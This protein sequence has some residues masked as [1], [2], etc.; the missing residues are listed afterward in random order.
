[1]NRQ[2][3]RQAARGARK[4]GSAASILAAPLELQSRFQNAVNLYQSGDLAA[5]ETALQSIDGEAPGLAEVCHLYGLILLHNGRP[6]DAIPLL[7]QA[8]KA[9]PRDPAAYNVL[10]GAVRAIGDFERAVDVY[11]KAIRCDGKFTDGHFNLANTYRDLNRLDE[12]TSHYAKAVALE[13]A[14]ADA[15]YNLGL[16]LNAL[17][18]FEDAEAAYREALV[19]APGDTDAMVGLGK[20]LLMQM[21]YDEAETQLRAAL[22]IDPQS[23]EAHNNLARALQGQGHTADAQRTMETAL[24][25]APN[26]GDLSINY[27]NILED[28]GKVDEAISAYREA[29]AQL[30]ESAEAHTN[31]GLLL[32]LDRQY[33]E[34]WREYDWRWR[35]DGRTPRPFPQPRWQG[36]DLADSTIL[37][38]AD[39]GAGDEILFASM[40]TELSEKAGRCI[41]ECDPRLAGLFS[42]A[43]PDI[44]VHPRRPKPAWGLTGGD[45]DCQ[46]PFSEMTRWLKPNLAEAQPPAAAYFTAELDTTETCRARYRARGDGLIVG[47]AW[48]SGNRRRPERNAPLTLWDPILTMP[49]L[50]FVSLQYGD[51]A[52]EIAETQ[53]RTGVEI[54]TDPEIDQF[55]SLEDFAGQVAAVDIVVSITNTTVHMAGALGKPVW[56][57]LPFMPDWRYQRDRDDT[58]WYPAMRLFRQSEPHR[59]DDLLTRVAAALVD[60]RDSAE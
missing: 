9:A 16:T 8:I 13:P 57:M 38:W 23:M 59:W 7:E 43:F 46:T 32:L 33:A 20:A 44:A 27:G 2:Q 48:A 35:R 53:E 14:F 17:E 39:E 54:F 21:R 10:G 31:L 29:I 49:G 58:P 11:K 37:A 60:F 1:M 56:T 3:R 45:I 47:I 41:V 42:R 22:E 6:L 12:A 26:R 51:H 5:A 18:R 40:L 30:P 55:A 34:G 36:E 28:Q 19:H 25:L 4:K 15:H 52:D 24:A 50:Q